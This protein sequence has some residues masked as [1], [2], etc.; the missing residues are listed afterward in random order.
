[1]K[2]QKLI[3]MTICALAVG[4]IATYGGVLLANKKGEPGNGLRDNRKEVVAACL[5]GLAGI[6]TKAKS[7]SRSQVETIGVLASHRAEEATET[8]LRIVT[9]PYRRKRFPFDH[10]A[11]AVWPIPRK[12][13]LVDY[14]AARALVAI[15]LPVI[16]G[17]Q[18]ELEASDKAVPDDRLNLYAK[19]LLEILGKMQ[20]RRFM[21]DESKYAPRSDQSLKNYKRLLALPELSPYKLNSGFQKIEVRMPPRKPTTGQSDKKVPG[22]K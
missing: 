5:K 1:M 16:T 8:L 7:L 19:I 14:P 2:A 6:D 11:S 4:V 10:S 17:I 3:L 9:V 12:K 15:G 21:L 22:A 20:V 13:P 18:I